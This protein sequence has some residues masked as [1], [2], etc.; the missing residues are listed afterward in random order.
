MARKINPALLVDDQD[1]TDSETLH[2]SIQTLID[3]YGRGGLSYYAERLGVTPQM[4][5]KRL[6][7]P[8]NAFDAPTLRAAVLVMQINDGQAQLPEP[9]ERTQA[10]EASTQ[11]E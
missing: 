5:Q 10:H 6:K 1:A 9:S 7:V 4:L 2:D 11:P 3:Q 8:G